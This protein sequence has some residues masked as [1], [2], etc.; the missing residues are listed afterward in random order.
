MTKFK[1]TLSLLA[2]VVVAPVGFAVEGNRSE[3]TNASDAPAPAFTD[4]SK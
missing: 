4:L 3:S 2:I 1:I